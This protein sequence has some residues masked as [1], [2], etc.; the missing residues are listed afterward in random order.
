M[1]H[2]LVVDDS[3]PIRDLCT[4]VLER[5]GHRIDTAEN[6]RIALDHIRAHA[7][8][9]VITDIVMPEMDGLDLIG[10][11]RGERP[12]LPMIAMSGNLPQ[13]GAYLEI[14]EQVG[15]DLC[16]AKPF[17]ISD[18]RAAVARALTSPAAAAGLNRGALVPEL[19][20]G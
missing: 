9:L 6:G 5:D 15:A 1:A 12:D 8:D 4:L 18:L 16:I 3:P 7:P 2:I 11:V 13:S 14:A 10:A 19:V 17:A 20:V